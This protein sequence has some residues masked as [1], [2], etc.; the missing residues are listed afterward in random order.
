V[1]S[2]DN[3]QCEILALGPNGL[4]SYD[5]DNGKQRWSIAIQ[6]GNIIA[7]PILGEEHTVVSMVMT[8]ENA[9]PFPD[10]DSDGIITYADIPTDPKEWM[11]T[12]TLRM[13]ADEFGD[14]DGK[15]TKAEWASFWKQFA[16]KPAITATSIGAPNE[17]TPQ[18][19]VRIGRTVRVPK[20]AGNDST[21]RCVFVGAAE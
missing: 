9:P 13:L 5:S 12:R 7:S 14:R 10:K 4:I 21:P 16:G 3:G 11:T 15:I 19:R 1:R 2:A 8:A 20:K 6:P 18:P 17:K